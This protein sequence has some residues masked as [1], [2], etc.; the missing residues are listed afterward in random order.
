MPQQNFNKVKNNFTIL[1]EIMIRT[2]GKVHQSVCIK[3]E[4]VEIKL[5]MILNL[6]LVITSI[7]LIV[8]LRINYRR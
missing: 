7:L 8:I 4:E 2:I 6:Q 3:Q 1:I 5:D